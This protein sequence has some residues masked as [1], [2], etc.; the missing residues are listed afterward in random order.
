MRNALHYYLL[1][2]GS[3]R[4]RAYLDPESWPAP[5]SGSIQSKKWLELGFNFQAHVEAVFGAKMRM[6][7]TKLHREQIRLLFTEHRRMWEQEPLKSSLAKL[8]DDKEAGEVIRSLLDV[9]EALCDMHAIVSAHPNDTHEAERVLEEAVHKFCKGLDT[10]DFDKPGGTPKPCQLHRRTYEHIITDHLIK[11]TV[12]LHKM[13][14][15]LALMSSRYL[16]ANNKV[17]KSRYKSLPGGGRQREGSYCNEPVFL[18]FSH[19]YQ[20]NFV[21][22]RLLW[23]K[24]AHQRKEA[25]K[26]GNVRVEELVDADADQVKDGGTAAERECNTIGAGGVE[27]AGPS[28]T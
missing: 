18:T 13:G 8:K 26:A 5:N 3:V 12:G 24:V 20:H 10:L 2:D 15:S 22:R 28:S 16:E 7:L 17:V 19:L 14:L 21:K 6:P 11:Q 25:E 4:D 23:K 1:P 9:W 27:V